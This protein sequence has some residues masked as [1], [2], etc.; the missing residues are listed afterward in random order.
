[1]IDFTLVIVV[2]LLI[3]GGLLLRSVVKVK[4]IQE[5]EAQRARDFQAQM[6][7]ELDNPSEE[8]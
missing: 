4:R 6:L 7:S 8:L 5:A 1:M 3:F 2:F